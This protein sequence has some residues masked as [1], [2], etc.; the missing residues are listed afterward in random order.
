MTGVSSLGR[1]LS[2]IDRLQEQQTLLDKLAVQLSTGRKTQ[3]F[4][5]LGTQVIASQR[6]HTSINT[7][8]T[9]VDNI[10]A[11]DTR[12]ELT[13]QAIE[14][15][16][17]QAENF[18]AALKGFMQEGA[19]QLGEPVYYDD[20]LTP[21]VENTLIGYTSA[22]ADVELQ[23]LQDMA[24]SLYDYMIDLVNS[25]DGNRYLL[26]GANTDTAP[27]SNTGALTS[28]MSSK[29]TAWQNGT[30]TT[31]DFIADI[32]DRS[33]DG[34]NL[35]AL[36]D[37]VVGY[38]STLSADTA[39][40]VFVRVDTHSEIDYTVLGD[41]Q[42]FRDIM[43]ALSFFK[44]ED[45]G[46]I[47]DQVEIDATTGLPVV[48]T[49]GAPGATIDEQTDNFYAIFNNLSGMVNRA[50]DE[51]DQ[52]RFRIESAR[53]RINDIKSN[54]LEEKS[55]LQS[56][57]DDIENVDINEVAVHITALQTQLEASYTVTAVT[58]S[59]SLINFL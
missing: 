11:A 29:F 57:I 14:E 48:I 6:A 19:H 30:L 24:A 37:T 55:L 10:S 33:I 56:T 58:Q 8:Q 2:N 43:V 18:D 35:D 9:Y 39:G 20:P 40:R 28:A 51:L 45:L 26:S 21:E 53:A 23:T 32:E 59:L 38:S 4:T 5:G 7:I 22:E 52:Q 49:E 54:Y 3:S 13:L 1:A 44:S 15:F 34:G 27:L 47:A 36:T 46:P 25:K 50:I 17:L 16:K 41:D 31:D 42:G 12:M